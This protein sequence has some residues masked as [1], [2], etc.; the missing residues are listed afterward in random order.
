M[1]LTP[2]RLVFEAMKWRSVICGAAASKKR[3]V[4]FDCETRRDGGRDWSRLLYI[5]SLVRRTTGSACQIKSSIRSS[6]LYLRSCPPLLPPTFGV[7]FSDWRPPNESKDRF[8]QT[9][10]Q[11][12]ADRKTMFLGIAPK[13][14]KLEKIV[15]PGRPMAPSRINKTSAAPA[16]STAC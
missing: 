8:V 15:E 12:L 7:P 4:W 9:F 16:W 1:F 2:L 14:Q 10:C 6:I 11:I 13:H 3:D 5:C